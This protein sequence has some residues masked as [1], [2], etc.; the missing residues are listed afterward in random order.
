MFIIVTSELTTSGSC[1]SS[2]RANMHFNHIEFSSPIQQVFSH[3]NVNINYVSAEYWVNCSQ[4]WNCC[5][6]RGPLPSSP[7]IVKLVNYFD[8]YLV[9]KGSILYRVYWLPW[10]FLIINYRFKF[11]IHTINNC[12]SFLN[13]LIKIY[14]LENHLFRTER[15]KIWTVTLVLLVFSGINMLI[16]LST[17]GNRTEVLVSQWCSTQYRPV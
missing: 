10:C 15:T 17:P 13:L 9:L 8:K 3:R 11:I 16:I 1:N 14:C 6:Y 2:Y 5:S 4:K 7:T 12:L